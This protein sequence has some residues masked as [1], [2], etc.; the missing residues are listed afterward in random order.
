MDVSYAPE[1]ERYRAE[2]GDF[3]SQNLPRDWGG[4]AG[5][6]AAQRPGFV[7]QWRILLGQQGLVAPAWPVEYGGGGLSA[8]ERVILHEEFAKAGVP[9]GGPNDG[10]GISMIGPTLMVLGTAM[11]TY[12][13]KLSDEQEVLSYAADILIDLFAAESAVLRARDA[14]ATGHGHSELHAAAARVFVHEA[15]QRIDMAARSVLA[16]MSEGDT[17]RT[18]LA[19]LR[20]FLKPT[21]VNTVALRR[22]LADAARLR[23]GLAS[24]PPGITHACAPFNP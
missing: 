7:K 19:A 11:Q 10:M 23:R 3:L 15:A 20:R 9:T 21:P 5:L 14:Q 13:E 4:L 12:G 16:A 6:P 17:L 8:I 24:L 1:A 22:I 2:I 18:L